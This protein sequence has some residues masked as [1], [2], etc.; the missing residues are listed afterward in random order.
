MLELLALREGKLI[1][2]RIARLAHGKS[3]AFATILRWHVTKSDVT[4]NPVLGQVHVV[5]R[6]GPG[7][8]GMSATLMAAPIRT[9]MCLH[10]KSLTRTRANS[11]AAKTNQ[12]VSVPEARPHQ[13]T[14]DLSQY[15]SRPG[16][17]HLGEKRIERDKGGFVRLW[18]A[19]EGC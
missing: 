16:H 9:L 4:G 8:V 18:S 17:H 11:S 7:G 13:S 19:D 2:W 15:P 5:T 3:H 10:N 12:L 1:E 6:L 14:V